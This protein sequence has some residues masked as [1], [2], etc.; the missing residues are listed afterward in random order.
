VD[1]DEHGPVPLHDVLLLYG[2]QFTRFFPEWQRNAAFFARL[3][4]KNLIYDKSALF[5]C[6]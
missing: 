2:V 3:L 5:L 4:K 1:V 6:H